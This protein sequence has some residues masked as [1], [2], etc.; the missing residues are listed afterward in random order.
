MDET[1]K[2]TILKKRSIDPRFPAKKGEHYIYF[3]S[4]IVLVTSNIWVDAFNTHGAK[5]AIKAFNVYSECGWNYFFSD[6]LY[7]ST[8]V[9]LHFQ[10]LGKKKQR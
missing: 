5:E 8:H 10:W 9:Y 6:E 7:K 1:S 2:E 4:F 3:F